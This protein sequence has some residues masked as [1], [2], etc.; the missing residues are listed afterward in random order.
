M[1]SRAGHNNCGGGEIGDPNL[2]PF[3]LDFLRAGYTWT[4]DLCE[5]DSD[6]DGLTNGEELGD[7]CCLFIEGSVLSPSMRNATVS[8]PGF[9]TST[10]VGYVRPD[11][12]ANRAAW[13]PLE[14]NITAVYTADDQLGTT[15]EVVYRVNNISVP[16]D[17]A[18][19]Y[20][21]IFF[22]F[23]F[24]E[25]RD[26]V[27]IETLVD[28]AANLHHFIVRRTPLPF[29]LPFLQFEVNDHI[30]LKSRRIPISH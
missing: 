23:E 13:T 2:N 12:V 28:K 1:L 19:S 3:G 26:I 27:A 10:V 7:P 29:F 11:C 20:F 14:P 9:N 16:S 21:N 30:T 22:N 25:Q 4:K 18:T 17:T 15:E 8:H 6:G 5:A 24:A